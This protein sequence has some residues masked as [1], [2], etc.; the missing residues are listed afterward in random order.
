MKRARN[1]NNNVDNSKS[2]GIQANDSREYGD[3]ENLFAP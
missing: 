1:T 2:P 3:N